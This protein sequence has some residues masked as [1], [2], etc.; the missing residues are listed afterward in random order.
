MYVDRETYTTVATQGRNANATREEKERFSLTN[1]YSPPGSGQ[2][3]QDYTHEREWRVF[4]KVNIR[5]TK[6]EVVITPTA[7]L[8]SVKSLVSDDEIILPIDLLMEWGV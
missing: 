1:L 5:E 3:I 4:S 8:D 6:P 7:Y 2:R